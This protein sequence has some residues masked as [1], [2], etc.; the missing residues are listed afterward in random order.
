MP[1]EINKSDRTKLKTYFVR[2][3]IPTEAN[4]AELIDA[5]L[6]QKGD[7]IAK[8]ANNPL[9]VEAGAGAPGKHVLNFYDSF[10][11]PR[12]AWSFS[13]Q[14]ADAKGL[15]ISAGT[16]GASPR[17]FI[18]AATGNVG[19]GTAK[20]SDPLDVDGSVR[21]LTGSNPIRFTDKWTG[22][23]DN[24][25]NGA[26]ISNDTDG[27]KTLMIVGNRAA[28]LGRRVSVWD[29][30]EVNGTFSVTQQEA[31]TNVT[32]TP[33]PRT[34]FPFPFGVQNFGQWSDYANG[35]GPVGYYK[36]SLGRVHLRGLIK[37]GFQGSTVFVLPA[38]YRP[39]SRRLFTCVTSPGALGRFDVAADGSA[40]VVLGDPGWLS[41]DGISFSTH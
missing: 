1:V 16:A 23:P 25:L 27:Y 41:L 11:D 30:L 29:R 6:N 10:A 36:D 2:N 31:W 19:V 7:G 26:E 39:T 13:L 4:F 34:N 17:L 24:K 35:Y 38:G 33:A 32:F 5:T 18:D 20:P 9:S 40:I 12:P 22:F 21:L 28:G 14:T 37:G 3:A 15:G 8:A